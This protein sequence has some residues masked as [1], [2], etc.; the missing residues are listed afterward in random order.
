VTS[1]SW[2]ETRRRRLARS[3]L[4]ERAPREQLVE[5]V[6]EVCGVQAQV[7]AAAE[8][9]I[10]ARVEG[11]THEDVR[12]ELWE[13]RLLVKTWT[14]R[15]T[16]H[17]HPADEL[18]LWTAATR[19]VG[20]PWYEAYGL[21]EADGAAVLDAIGAALDGRCL[22]REELADEVAKRAG[23][24]SRERIGSGWGYIIGSAAA[25]GKLC[26]GPP[27][28]AKVTFVRTDQWVGWHE[29]DPDEALA[30]VCR[31]FLTAYGPAGPRQFAEWFGMKSPQARPL[32]E[33]LAVE[34]SPERAEDLGPLRLL[35]EYDCYVMGFR[36]REHLV[37]E[38][39]RERVKV[40]PRGRFEG[41]AGVPMLLVDGVVTG[42]WRRAKRGKRVQIVVEPSR[43]LKAE[44]S[45]LLEE[46]AGRIGTFLGT[47][48]ELRVGRLDG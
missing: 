3:H 38:E 18:P 39:V 41:I 4:L 44:E 14:M 17:L 2:E 35:P 1:L 32:V 25:V 40:H 15:G 36:E 23:E 42:L 22:L 37:P 45:R 26:H 24:W 19:A 7:M 6:R 10:G 28:G 27:R 21:D 46:E 12:A 13:R 16:L 48:P 20:P 43:R 5:V 47:E 30:E 29:V 33:S 11:V 9:A 8:L 34:V 31:R